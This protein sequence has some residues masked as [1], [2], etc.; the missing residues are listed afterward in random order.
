MTFSI[1]PTQ[2]NDLLRQRFLERQAQQ[3]AQ[4]SN[5]QP[6]LN[7]AQN[8]QP[9]DQT[10]SADKVASAN[11]PPNAALP[12]GAMMGS[13]GLSPQGSKEADLSAIGAKIAQMKTQETDST[14]KSQIANLEEQYNGY[15]AVAAN[16]QTPMQ[17]SQ[18]QTALAASQMTGATQAGLNNLALIEIRKKQPE[19]A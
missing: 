6:N 5:Q 8:I 17:P 18:N 13:M 19:T 14:Q 9:Q 3:Q 1:K 2:N 12:W 16:M 7:F 4:V 11:P 15:K 10:Q